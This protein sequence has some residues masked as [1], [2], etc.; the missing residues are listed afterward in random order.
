MKN[1]QIIIPVRLLCVAQM[2]KWLRIPV[3]LSTQVSSIGSTV[4]CGD[5]GA[6]KNEKLLFKFSTKLMFKQIIV[7]NKW[8]FV[9]ITAIKMIKKI[10]SSIL[11]YVTLHLNLS[12]YS[13]LSR[14]RYYTNFKTNYFLRNKRML[15][16]SLYFNLSSLVCLTHVCLYRHLC[17]QEF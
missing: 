1:V 11:L 3:A 15:F 5:L 13:E 9:L 2:M 4:T 17:V 16:I 14:T 10:Q 7:S 6:D 8:L 12:V